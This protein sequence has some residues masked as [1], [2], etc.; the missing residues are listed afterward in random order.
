MAGVASGGIVLPFRGRSSL[1]S[2][3]GEARGRFVTQPI[4]LSPFSA[5]LEAL[6][7]I[8]GACH[9]PGWDGYGAVSVRPEAIGE[10]ADFLSQLPGFIEAPEA[11]PEPD[12]C[13]ALE[14]HTEEV[15]QLSIS[16]SGTGAIDYAGVFADGCCQRGTERF[17]GFIPGSISQLLE[18]RFTRSGTDRFQRDRGALRAR[19]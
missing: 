10:A 19:T 12:G 14:W 11:A 13:V 17:L 4:S 5:T 15:P 1:T 18:A 2:R 8:S 16:F 6:F 7:S 3:R 9:Q